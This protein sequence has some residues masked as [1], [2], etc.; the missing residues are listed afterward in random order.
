MGV[1]GGHGAG[2]G[3]GSGVGRPGLPVGAVCVRGQWHCCAAHTDLA[4]QRLLLLEGTQEVPEPCHAL[5]SAL[6]GSGAW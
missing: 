5:G 4:V 1:L 2:A 6:P 3:T